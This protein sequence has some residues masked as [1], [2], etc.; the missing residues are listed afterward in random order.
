MLRSSA[1]ATLTG[2]GGGTSVAACDL[3]SPQ[4]LRNA[5]RAIAAAVMDSGGVAFIDMNNLVG[6]A[7]VTFRA[8]TVTPQCP[9]AFQL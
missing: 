6:P 3:D 8:D 1:A 4:A 9:D 5:D 2:G 7:G